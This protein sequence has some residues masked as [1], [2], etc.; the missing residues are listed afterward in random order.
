MLRQMPHVSHFILDGFVG[1][2]RTDESALPSFLKQVEK[3]RSI[4]VLADRET[5][6]T[7]HPSRCRWLGWNETQKQ[8]SPSTNP[9]MYEAISIVKDQ[10]R[11][12]MLPI[13][14]GASRDLN[15]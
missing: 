1:S 9:E 4:R 11:R 3:L 6:R 7:S 13:E 2:I 5:G 10:G 14:P 8:P 15:P 12:F